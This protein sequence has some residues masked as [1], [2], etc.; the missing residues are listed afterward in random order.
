M[1]GLSTKTK[2]IA[3]AVM[4]GLFLLGGVTGAAAM[5]TYQQRQFRAQLQQGPGPARA[6]MRLRAMRRFLDLTDDQTREI[7]TIL[8]EAETKHRELFEQCG[9]ELKKLRTDT[10][11]KI[12]AVLSEEQRAAYE[13]LVERR[14]KGRRGRRGHR[15]RRG[16][17][18]VGPPPEGP[19]PPGG[20][21][22][23]GPPP[24]EGP[25]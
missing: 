3:V 21:P 11:A 8:S 19:P 23:G 14:R 9:P 1:A 16:R 12:E 18:P 17:P 10:E 6:K 25:R 13:K 15:G 4:V 22:P 7:E 24:P 20:P 2:V 5:R